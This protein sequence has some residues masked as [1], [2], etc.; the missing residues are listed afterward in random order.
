[1]AVNIS[2]LSDGDFKGS[3]INV[4]TSNFIHSHTDVTDFQFTSMKA[5]KFA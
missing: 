3:L 4:F 2:W 1:M 5:W